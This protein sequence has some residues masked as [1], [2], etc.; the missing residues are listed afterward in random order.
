MRVRQP[1]PR[2]FAV[3]LTVAII[4]AGC[5]QPIGY[6]AQ[7]DIRGIKFSGYTDQKVGENE[8]SV[9]AVGY[10]G[11]LLAKGT[12]KERIAQLA[13]L[14]AA[15]LT[16]E[17][18]HQRFVIIHGTSSRQRIGTAHMVA[19]PGSAVPIV[20]SLGS[21]DKP[22][23]ILIIKTLNDEEAPPDAFDAKAIEAA[24]APVFE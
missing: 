3:A 13:L 9:V 7:E 1:A 6:R 14:R 4:L 11:A 8:H 15:R 2:F 19:I 5:D 17:Q 20:V 22:T 10:G 12:T 18:G 21:W 16:L 23:A 24:L